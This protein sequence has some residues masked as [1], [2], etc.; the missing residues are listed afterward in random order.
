M[1]ADNQLGQAN[2]ERYRRIFVVILNGLG[3]GAAPDALRFDD[4]GADTLG[5]L[6]AHFRARLS[7][8][9][10]GRLGLGNLCHVPLMGMPAVV[11]PQGYFGKMRPASVGNDSVDA[12]WELIGQPLLHELTIFPA[13]FPATIINQL[14]R[15]SG[16]RL[17]DNHLHSLPWAVYNYGEEQLATGGV[18]VYTTGESML[19]LAAHE[20]VISPT[21]LQR[22]GRLVRQLFD[23]SPDTL[24]W[25]EVHGFRGHDRRHFYLTDHHFTYERHPMTGT[26]LDRL[27]D[28]GYRVIVSGQARQHYGIGRPS[29]EGLGLSQALD[30]SFVGLYITEP[31]DF[32]HRFGY[33]R[34][35]EGFG[36]ALMEFDRQ[37][38]DI[39]PRLTA[40]DLLIITADHGNDPT[41]RGTS[42]TR[43]FVPLLAYS[44]SMQSSGSLG[45]RQTL[46]DV[47]QTILANFG[48]DGTE[49]AGKSFLNKLE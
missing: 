3:V 31:V 15:Q 26:I 38:G 33:Q 21:E 24:G 44:P 14:A 36:Q 30:R 29:G 18:I 6:G 43:E 27:R 1:R 11:K 9:N 7:L 20:D 39:L 23:Q 19:G 37:L 8:P 12:H 28:A 4:L 16:H 5:H 17:L 49:L 34:N 35:P 45:I 47:G 41:F 22:T 48:L 2:G 10:L 40:A 42:H 13:G 46:A 25:V 32:D